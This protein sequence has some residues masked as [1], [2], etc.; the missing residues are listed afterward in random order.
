MARQMTRTIRHCRECLA[1]RE[2]EGD[3]AHCA[4]NAMT[5]GT[6][7]VGKAAPGWCPL[8]KMALVLEYKGG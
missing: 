2:T 5:F 8:R 6:H 7:P 4:L 3:N 1:F